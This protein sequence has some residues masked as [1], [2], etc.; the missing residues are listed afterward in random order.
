MTTTHVT[1]V[2]AGPHL[3]ILLATAVTAAPQ[4]RKLRLIGTTG[5]NIAVRVIFA[6]V[7][8]SRLV[9]MRLGTWYLGGGGGLEDL[10][11]PA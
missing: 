2:N 1:D 6:L 8:L 3:P 10:E 5:M 7:A 4:L 9:E 11:C